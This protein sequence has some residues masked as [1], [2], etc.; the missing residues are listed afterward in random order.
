MHI[1][2]ASCRTRLGFCSKG[3]EFASVSFAFM[4]SVVLRSWAASVFH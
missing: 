2:G 1:P 4:L 3:H